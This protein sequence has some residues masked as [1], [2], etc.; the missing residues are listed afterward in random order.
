VKVE[1]VAEE[2]NLTPRS[3][4]TTIP[5]PKINKAEP[6]KER[7]TSVSQSQSLQSHPTQENIEIEDE[8]YETRPPMKFIPMVEES[9]TAESQ[10]PQ[11]ALVHLIHEERFDELSD[12]LKYM[13]VLTELQ[14]LQTQ[15]KKILAALA[16]DDSDELTEQLKVITKKIKQLQPEHKELN[17]T[18]LKP[19]AKQTRVF[20]RW[21]HIRLLLQQC[22][23][24]GIN[25]PSLV[26]SSYW[27]CCFTNS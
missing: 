14:K 11:Q 13:K 23:T 12:C 17:L 3:G 24:T 10:T 26:S 4:I 1:V 19:R 16:E 22:T 18:W 27:L 6:S 25:I 5:T 7:S 21:A 20:L 2:H 9:D 8:K 15:K